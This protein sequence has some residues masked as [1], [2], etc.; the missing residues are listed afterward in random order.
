[1]IRYGWSLDHKTDWVFKSRGEDET[2]AV[3]K[4]L[5]GMLLWTRHFLTRLFLKEDSS[6]N[7]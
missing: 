4:P 6:P 2:F 3:I 5:L 1:M 7:T